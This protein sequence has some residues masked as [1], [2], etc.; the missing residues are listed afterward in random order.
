MAQ[1][2]WQPVAVALQL[3]IAEEKNKG[4][5]ELNTTCNKGLAFP[6]EYSR[7]TGVSNPFWKGVFY[8]RMMANA[9][10]LVSYR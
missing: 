9:V 1:T 4:I 8:L 2:C 10:P 3:K 6:E 7:C 5:S